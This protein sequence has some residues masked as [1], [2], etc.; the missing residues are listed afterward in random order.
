MAAAG[1]PDRRYRIRAAWPE[2]EAPP[3]GFPVLYL[4]DADATFLTAVEAARM[5]QRRAEVTGVTPAVIVGLDHAVD[6]ALRR[7][8]RS[9]DYTPPSAG[10]PEGTGGADR[11][12]DFLEREA[13]PALESQLPADPRRRTLFGHSFGGLLVLHALFAR[14]GLFRRHVAASPSIWWN[15]GAILE[16]ERRFTASPPPEAPSLGLLLTVGEMEGR[17]VDDPSLSAERRERLRQARM[18]GHAREMA[19]R[20]AALGAAGPA[21]EFVEFPGENHG[22]VLPAAI[23]RGLRAALSGR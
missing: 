18:A 23:S 9:R 22:S 16:S 12:L 1:D 2:G 5:Q 15:G 11:F 13:L 21:V 6:P 14:P 17:G 10:A 19:L 7:A 4:L 3:G 8:R 20:L